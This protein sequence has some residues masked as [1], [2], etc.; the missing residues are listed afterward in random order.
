MDD[1]ASSSAWLG[2]DAKFGECLFEVCADGWTYAAAWSPAGTSLAFTSHDCSTRFIDGLHGSANTW[3]VNLQP[4][5][6]IAQPDGKLPLREVTF[7]SDG[8][9]VAA[10]Y[11]GVPVLFQ[12]NVGVNG[13][14]QS[15]ICKGELGGGGKP[16]NGGGADGDKRS[17][18]FTSGLAKFKAQTD[19]GLDVASD[20]DNASSRGTRPHNNCVQCIRP[21]VA[22]RATSPGA[23]STFFTTSGL[24]GV[25]VLWEFA[26]A[27][28]A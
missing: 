11:D 9:V 21:A 10:G 17:S 23:S 14:V 18:Q 22:G 28:T 16:V 13:V 12:A 15:W 27:T 20:A 26:T 19:L 25:L 7:L 6:T 24:D 8:T 4:V 5:K 3:A 2:P 1:E